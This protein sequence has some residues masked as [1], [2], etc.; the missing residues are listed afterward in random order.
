MNRSRKKVA[1]VNSARTIFFIILA[2]AIAVNVFLSIKREYDEAY[3]EYLNSFRVGEY[4]GRIQ[5]LVDLSLWMEDITPAE[6]EEFQVL[7]VDLF[8]G[9]SKEKG[10]KLVDKV[11]SI[12]EGAEVLLYPNDANDMCGFQDGFMVV[13]NE[14]NLSIAYSRG[15]MSEEKYQEMNRRREEICEK[16][17]HRKAESFIQE[18]LEMN[19][20]SLESGN[21]GYDERGSSML[22]L[23]INI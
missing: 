22:P 18:A 21:R 12:I 6:Y 16:P 2:I 7:N 9:Y 14:V 5:V 19:R 23:L 15:I 4:Y 17:T 8:D 11:N 20:K 10:Q 1:K 13:G 3:A